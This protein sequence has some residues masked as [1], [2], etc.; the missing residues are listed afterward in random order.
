MTKYENFS[1]AI[2]R[3]ATGKNLVFV[4]IFINLTITV[5]LAFKLGIWTDEAYS[6]E[7]SSRTL[8]Y[9]AERALNFEMQPPVYFMLLT[10]WRKMDGSIFFARLLSLL[11]VSMTIYFS[12]KV[13]RRYLSDIN[14]TY[15]AGIIALN[16]FI[17]WAAVEVRRYALV[18]LLS[19]LMFWF[20]Y[21]GYIK[22][23]PRGRA[24]VSF[25]ITAAFG[26]Y[27]QY[28]IGLLLTAF[29]VAALI[30]G[31]ISRFLGFVKH[32]MIVGLIFLPMLFIMQ[33]QLSA[34]QNIGSVSIDQFRI[35]KVLLSHAENFIIPFNKLPLDRFGRWLIRIIA[36]VSLL[37][38]FVRGAR[39][40]N[41]SL[42]PEGL[43]GL[44]CVA[45]LLG[46]FYLILNFMREEYLQPRHIAFFFLPV[47]LLFFSVLA[48]SCSKKIVN[49]WIL[50]LL[51]FY[52]CAIYHFYKPMAKPGDFVRVTSHIT[53]NERPGQPILIF[54]YEGYL[55]IKYHYGGLNP[56]VPIRS[57]RA[58]NADTDFYIQALNNE[59]DIINSISEKVD[60]PEMLWVVKLPVKEVLGIPYNGE[61]LDRYIENNF[62]IE[63]SSTYFDGT[64]LML[65]NKIHN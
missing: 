8:L 4:I 25:I 6:L 15:L 26:L 16:P 35:L 36:I 39:R 46:Q 18:I 51:S 44:T 14:P 50:I 19:C 32:M 22:E 20:F 45:L 17:I 47:F 52:T 54:P 21:D 1:L 53:E 57:D 64:K 3:T 33:N 65:I 7:T 2:L 11:C 42:N 41:I 56:L 38:A 37:I 24:K 49:Y 31:N 59:L 5:P 9:A 10:L 12:T 29:G 23:R 43:I 30:S 34:V 27:T 48:I 13:S 28:Y 55:P 61:I 58:R 40:D 60:D 63:H 62:T